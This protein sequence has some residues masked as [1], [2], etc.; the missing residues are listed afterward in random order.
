ML[1]GRFF[2]TSS[3]GFRHLPGRPRRAVH[4]CGV[5]AH[6]GVTRVVCDLG[7]DEHHQLVE[8][9]LVGHEIHA[10]QTAEVVQTQEKAR[11]DL[12]DAGVVRRGCR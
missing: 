10:V 11:M 2:E 1:D 7:H 12:R 8:L 5:G 9:A 3:T 4:G 6:A